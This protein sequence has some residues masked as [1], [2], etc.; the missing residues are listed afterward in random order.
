MDI[1]II[2]PEFKRSLEACPGVLQRALVAQGVAK[3]MKRFG[4]IGLEPQGLPKAGEGFHQVA[5]LT[6]RV[7]QV[8]VDL[9]K[10]W[11]EPERLP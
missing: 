2:R 8:A 6:Q 10:I 4:V 7:A 9:G 11:P 5:L 3:V 1:Q